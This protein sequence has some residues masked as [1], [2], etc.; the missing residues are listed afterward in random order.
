MPVS[1]ENK[2]IILVGDVT[3]HGGTVLGGSS[4][5]FAE[6]LPVARVGDPVSCPLCKGVFP[7]VEGA[8]SVFETGLKIARHGDK[9]ACGATLIARGA[10]AG[11]GGRSDDALYA[12]AGPVHQYAGKRA[13]ENPGPMKYTREQLADM[14]RI[15][16]SDTLKREM[17]RALKESYITDDAGNVTHIQEQG[18]WLVKNADGSISLQRI[19]G[20]DIVSKQ[21]IE[22]GTVDSYGIRF[23]HSIPENAIGTFHTH[24]AILANQVPGQ[25]FEDVKLADKL[26]LPG[27]VLDGNSATKSTSGSIY[28]NKSEGRW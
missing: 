3:S 18:G 20:G 2:G 1:I 23:P 15:G 14:L 10:A 19:P 12:A 21:N 28:D 8:A 7:I 25:S 13:L 22:S 17:A 5:C 11:G 24:P 16:G 9:T 27:V 4:S 26:Q 6:G